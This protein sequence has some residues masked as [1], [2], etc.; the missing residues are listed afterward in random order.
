MP[1]KTLEELKGH[2]QKH[3]GWVENGFWL[4]VFGIAYVLMQKAMH[5]GWT[6]FGI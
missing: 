2:L 6:I 1:L 4:A 3:K 5:P